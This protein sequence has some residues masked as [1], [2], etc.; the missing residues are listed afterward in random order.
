[1][2]DLIL[3]QAEL[4][5]LQADL[6]NVI[7][8][9]NSIDGISQSV[10]NQVGPYGGLPGRVGDFAKGWD[11]RRKNISES[12]AIVEKVYAEIFKSFNDVDSKMA[13]VL[14]GGSKSTGT[15]GGKQASP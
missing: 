11:D 1:M 13:S 14:H 4:Q 2:S 8:S 12:L 7:T 10:A 3:N 9:F 6:Q 5:Q 15:S